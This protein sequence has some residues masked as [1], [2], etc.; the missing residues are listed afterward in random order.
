M[1]SWLILERRIQKKVKQQTNSDAEFRGSDKLRCVVCGA[2]PKL[3]KGEWVW[4]CKK[5][6]EEFKKILELVLSGKR[7]MQREITDFN[8]ET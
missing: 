4:V 5:H 3:G 7:R 8:V 2:Y 1:G 6:E